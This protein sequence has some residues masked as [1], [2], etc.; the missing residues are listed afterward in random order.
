MFKWIWT[1]FSLGAPDMTS[2]ERTQKYHT[3]D[4]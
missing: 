3:D 4:G 2:D 1:M